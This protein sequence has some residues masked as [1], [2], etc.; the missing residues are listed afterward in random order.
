SVSNTL[1]LL[2]GNG[3]GGVGD[4]TFAPPVPLAD[5]CFPVHAI[6]ADLDGNGHPD[7]VTCGY[8]SGSLGIFHDGCAPDPN[9]PT[10]TKI[11]DVP[12]HQGGKVFITWTKSGLDVTGGAVT[13]YT[14]WRLVPPAG[15]VA[16]AAMLAALP[17][18]PQLVRRELHTRAN[19][20]T[21]ID[22]WEAL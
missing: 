4:G 22:Y 3:S 11:R 5:C 6:A 8:Q 20:T 19:G 15:L 21:D 14:V 18:D 7:V 2:K 1:F 13:G 10:T 17:S 12:H 9:I 16:H